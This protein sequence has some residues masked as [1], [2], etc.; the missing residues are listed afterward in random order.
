MFVVVVA[1]GFVVVVVSDVVFGVF[2]V[3]AVVVAGGVVVSASFR[4]LFDGC[5][6]FVALFGEK[7]ACGEETCQRGF[8]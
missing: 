4:M 6:F 5:C 3:V 2:D 1:S 8:C 7:P